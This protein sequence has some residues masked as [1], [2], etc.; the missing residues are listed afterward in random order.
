[1][2]LPDPLSFSAAWVAAWNAHDVEA[3]LAHFH[4]DVVFTSPTAARLVP[5]SD[6]VVR[7]KAEL[8]RY[9]TE[10]LRLLPGLHFTVERV[11]AGIDV[12]VIGYRNQSGGLVDEVLRFADGLVVEGHGTYL[13]ADD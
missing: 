10:G 8:R 4:E 6:G 12:L 3:V 9:W 1:M 5:G 13:V 7:G 2:T 11:F